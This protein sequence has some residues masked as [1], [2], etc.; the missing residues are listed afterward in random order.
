M[1]PGAPEHARRAPTCLCVAGQH[2]AHLS[3]HERTRPADRRVVFHLCR[4]RFATAANKDHA[5]QASGSNVRSTECCQVSTATTREDSRW[6]ETRI[7]KNAGCHRGAQGTLS[8]DARAEMPKIEDTFY[9]LATSHLARSETASRAPPQRL[10]CHLSP[11]GPAPPQAA[12]ALG[13][14]RAHAGLLFESACRRALSCPRPGR[15]RGPQ[16]AHS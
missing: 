3:L 4:A 16:P 1:R 12:P 7:N 10:P 2:Q 13:I 8:S 14:L 11:R 9:T 15:K 6:G 5:T